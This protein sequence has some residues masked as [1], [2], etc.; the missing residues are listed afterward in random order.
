[1]NLNDIALITNTQCSIPGPSR[2][3]TKPYSA[4]HY[5]FPSVGFLCLQ[6]RL[7]QYEYDAEKKILTVKYCIITLRCLKRFTVNAGNHGKGHLSQCARQKQIS[8]RTSEPI[9]MLLN[10]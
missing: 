7:K 6:L 10:F 3:L 1:M 8:F 2:S 4:K 9:S 5:R